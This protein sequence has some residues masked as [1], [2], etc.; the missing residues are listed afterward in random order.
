MHCGLE[1]YQSGQKD[2]YPRPYTK[3]YTPQVQ[4]PAL[5]ITWLL[6][7]RQNMCGR[8]RGSAARGGTPHNWWKCRSKHWKLEK[9]R[10]HW[11]KREW[12]HDPWDDQLWNFQL[13]QWPYAELVCEV[14]PEGVLLRPWHFWSK[15]KVKTHL[16]AF[17]P[18]FIKE[19]TSSFRIQ[20]S[21]MAY[22]KWQ[23]RI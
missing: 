15:W 17:L 1:P 12:G 11:W 18:R 2:M 14:W 8:L 10:M 21:I 13:M 5:Q 16:Q 3:S 23:L 20:S 22:L 19:K 7:Q 4:A 9:S 6:L